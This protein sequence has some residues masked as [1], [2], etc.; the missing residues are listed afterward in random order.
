MMYGKKRMCSSIVRAADDSL[1]FFFFQAGDG[2]RDSPVTGVQTCALPI[3]DE[4][5]MAYGVSNH[6]Q[7][8]EISQQLSELGRQ[9]IH[10]TFV[11]H[12]VP[13]ARGILITAYASLTEGTTVTDVQE[14]YG[15]AYTGEAFVHLIDEPP[16]TKWAAGGNHAFVHCVLHGHTHPLVATPTTDN[17]GN[18]AA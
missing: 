9:V 4:N 14:A 10:I 1:C 8:P 15:Q 16:R 18:T 13:M 3:F 17:R 2:I 12:L 11:P 6:Y 5:A 7:S